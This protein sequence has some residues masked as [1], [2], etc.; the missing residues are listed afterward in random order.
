VCAWDRAGRAWSDDA[1]GPQDGVALSTDLHTLLERAQLSGPFVLAGHSFGGLSALNYAE[2]YPNEVAGMVLLDGTSTEMFT[3][4]RSYP[5]VYEVYRRVSALFPSLARLG[6]GRLAYRS[7]FD[8][9][10]AQAQ[11]EE[12]AFWSTARLARSQR[13]E[14]GQAPIL[15]QQARALKSLNERPLIVVTAGRNAQDGWIPLQNELAKLSSNSGHRILA[16][17]EH[18]SL[19]TNEGD[20]RASTQAIVDV[21]MAVRTG[22]SLANERG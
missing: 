16:N 17:T 14:W 9:L 10:P 4:L 8:S 19:T 21:V 13:D 12:R 2:R 1:A 5:I 15:M 6:V 22:Q 18:A 3:R 7:A 11:R 20:A